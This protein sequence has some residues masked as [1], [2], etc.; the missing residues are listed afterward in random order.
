MRIRSAIITSSAGLAGVALAIGAVCLVTQVRWAAGPLADAGR[1][2]GSLQQRAAVATAVEQATDAQA[3]Y[4]RTR[5]VDQLTLAEEQL[6]RLTRHL[7]ALDRHGIATAADSLHRAGLRL[8][9]VLEG[10]EAT[11]AELLTAERTC[12]RAAR[13]LRSG[14]RSLRTS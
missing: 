6:T 5:D 14:S 3:A 12:D 13:S 1:G 2:V 11:A 9:A 10:A 4:F 7:E 8:G